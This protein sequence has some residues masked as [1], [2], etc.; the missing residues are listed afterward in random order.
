MQAEEVGQQADAWADAIKKI[1]KGLSAVGVAIAGAITAVMM[2]WPD[3]EIQQPTEQYHPL[4]R[5]NTIQIGDASVK[6]PIENKDCSNFLNTVNTKWSEEQ[7]GVWEHL[8]RE[9]GC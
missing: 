5:E 1:V 3:S 4:T 7:W 2:L 6:L 8:K 9:A